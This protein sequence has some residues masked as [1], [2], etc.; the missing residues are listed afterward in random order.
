[1]KRKNIKISYT[2]VMAMDT[3]IKFTKTTC[4]KNRQKTKVKIFF[5]KNM[6]NWLPSAS[7]LKIDFFNI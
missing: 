6:L 1:M 3:N 7:G 2:W 4:C 5:T